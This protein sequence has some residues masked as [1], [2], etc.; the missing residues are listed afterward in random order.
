MNE[1]MSFEDFISDLEWEWHRKVAY[2]AKEYKAMRQAPEKA[3]HDTLR[4]ELNRLAVFFRA[5]DVD[6]ELF[7]NAETGQY[8]L[9]P[10]TADFFYII[11]HYYN[12]DSY[13]H[14]RKLEFEK[15][16]WKDLI[17]I[18]F[19]LFNALESI[20]VSNEV[21]SHTFT[22]FDQRT[23]CPNAIES[24][25]MDE[26][27]IYLSNKIK[28]NLALPQLG[29][30]SFFVDDSQLPIP[31]EDDD[32]FYFLFSL[33]KD[34]KHQQSRFLKKW[35]NIAAKVLKKRKA[36]T[37]KFNN[38]VH[39]NPAA[40]RHA[41][42]LRQLQEYIDSSEELRSLDESIL[43]VHSQKQ[44]KGILSL[45][46]LTRQRESLLQEIRQQ[47][48]A[49][50]GWSVED[51]QAYRKILEENYIRADSLLEQITN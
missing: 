29:A 40:E 42:R 36:L 10:E 37:Q 44:R 30:G 31:M 43:T 22:R 19:Q 14:I 26:S 21:L 45:N 23:G 27:M 33:Y 4:K 48:I 20:G 51:E 38:A 34:Y 3:S 2:Q 46:S 1:K 35:D 16:P 17:T 25:P 50:N 15:V 28:R 39:A 6:M 32:W 8:E 13:R 12:T 49:Q 24:F 5:I 18:R 9:S 11:F 41:F 7:K 47:Y